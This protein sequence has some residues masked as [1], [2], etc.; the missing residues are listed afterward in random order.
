[1]YKTLSEAHVVVC[2]LESELKTKDNYIKILEK[3]TNA[4]DTGLKAANAAIY[5]DQEVIKEQDGLLSMRL[6]KI[7]ELTDLNT[8]LTEAVDFH[9]NKF[10]IRHIEQQA[11][12]IAELEKDN[13]TLSE[14]RYFHKNKS[15]IQLETIKS[16][17]YKINK[18]QKDFE[19]YR[20]I[21][22]NNKENFVLLSDYNLL[23]KK[24]ESNYDNCVRLENDLKFS[25]SELINAE[26]NA[27]SLHSENQRL[28]QSLHNI[29]D[30][31]LKAVKGSQSN[32]QDQC[33]SLKSCN[34]PIFW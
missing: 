20:S 29:S 33:I 30:K 31:A 18:L 34:A 4:Q 17:Q 28:K 2:Q 15:A 24:S 13:E 3:L 9:K 21:L 27:Q 5:A 1:M 11:N 16:Q 19:E 7:N 26:K 25:E 14:D 10:S 22:D 8:S 23:Q 32:N 6:D 12:K